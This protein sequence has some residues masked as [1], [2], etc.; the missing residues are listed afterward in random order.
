IADLQH[1]IQPQFIAI[2]AI[3]AGEGRML[4]PTPFPLGL[5]IMGNS[6]IAFDSVCCHIIGVDP[7]TVDHIRLA[8]EHGF[9]STDISRVK[10]TGDVSLDEAKAR[11]KGFKVGLIRVEKYFEGTH[12][13]A[14]AGP[15]PASE[16]GDYCWGGCPGAIEEAIEILRVFDKDTDKKMPRLHVVFG[17][18]QGGIDAKPGERV[19][20]I[21][22]CA[23][24]KGQLHGKLV[25]IQSVYKERNTLDPHTATAQDVFAK[26]ASAKGKMSDEVIRLEGCPVSVAEQVLALI[27]LS[28]VK[29]PYYDRENMLSFG[30]AYLG[31][32]TRVALNRLQRKRYQQ[33]GTF[34][35]RGQAAPDLAQ[36]QH[37]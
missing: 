23:N 3:T 11:A 31:W 35:E 32:K 22:D 17:A 25:Q 6:Q 36:E 19:V 37:A 20:F 15:P 34:R 30:R 7:N 14:Y 13:S 9:G 1:I 12:I 24:W 16:D 18:Y 27:S 33:N 26:L 29:N 8:S 28:G 2:D 10:I 4:T 21:G 5:I